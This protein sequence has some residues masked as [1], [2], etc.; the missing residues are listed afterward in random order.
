MNIDVRRGTDRTDF[1]VSLEEA[2]GEVKLADLNAN[3]DFIS[4]RRDPAFC[5][6]FSWVYLFR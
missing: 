1:H 4:V 2:F 5:F 6:R 3:Y